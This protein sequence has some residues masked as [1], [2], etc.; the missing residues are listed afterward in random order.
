[1]KVLVIAL[2]LG[3]GAIIALRACLQYSVATR[4]AIR[5]PTG[6][7]A[8]EKLRLGGVDQWIQIR[9]WDQHKPVL[10]FLHSGPGFPEM[11]FSY[12]N[13]GLEKDFVVVQ[14][15]QRGAGKSYSSMIDE[16]SMNVEQFI[17]DTRELSELLNQRFGGK[18][19]L[20]AHSWGTLIG[21]LTAS[22]HPQLF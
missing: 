19:F 3:V 15:D 2:L 6:I 11:P 16:K 1:M 22:R 21:T 12:V 4:I 13:S 14:W 10:L 7:A 17:S 8:L 20:V 9:G 18:I 5:S